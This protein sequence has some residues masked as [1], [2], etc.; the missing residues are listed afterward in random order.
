MPLWK[1]SHCCSFVLLQ[2]V[3]GEGLLVVRKIEN[4]ATGPNN[5]PKLPCVIVECG[6]EIFIICISDNWHQTRVSS[7]GLGILLQLFS[8]QSFSYFLFPWYDL[9]ALSLIVTYILKFVVFFYHLHLRQTMK[10]WLVIV[11]MSIE[12]LS[13]TQIWDILNKFILS[14][15]VLLTD[16]MKKREGICTQNWDRWGGRE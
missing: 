4:V 16:D 6:E 7:W 12:K 1:F 13:W 9:F 2:R 3:L 8:H 15:G 10:D 5:R 14:P 11:L